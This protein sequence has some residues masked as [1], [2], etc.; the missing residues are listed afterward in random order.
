MTKLMHSTRSNVLAATRKVNHNEE[1]K[2]ASSVNQPANN[3]NNTDN[4]IAPY[5][6]DFRGAFGGQTDRVW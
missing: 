5:G 3:N 6:R 2:V 4:S 1:G